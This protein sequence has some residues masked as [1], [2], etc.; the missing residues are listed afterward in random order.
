MVQ[1]TLHTEVWSITL[2][3]GSRQNRVSSRGKYP[4]L[5][6]LL[7]ICPPPS[8]LPA[9]TITDA[10]Y[11]CPI[12]RARQSNGDDDDEIDSQVPTT[13]AAAV[14]LIVATSFSVFCYLSG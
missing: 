4:L 2:L 3:N 8:D 11:T 5:L 14:A 13:A 9:I 6:L 12:G 1:C 7:L 10:L